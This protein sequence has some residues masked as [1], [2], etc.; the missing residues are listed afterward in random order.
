MGRAWERTE[1]YIQ[2]CSSNIKGHKEHLGIFLKC[3]FNNI[4]GV[5][6]TGAWSHLL[7]N[8]G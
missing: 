8:K 1:W 3:S 2:Q 6:A 4:K 7:S 5:D